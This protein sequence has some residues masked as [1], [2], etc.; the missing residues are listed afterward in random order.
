[1]L[2]YIGVLV[3]AIAMGIMN[4]FCFIYY[5]KLSRYL[6][7]KGEYKEYYKHINT[8]FSL[9]LIIV[10]IFTMFIFPIMI[11]SSITSS[12]W[13]LNIRD[14]IVD[15]YLYVGVPTFFIT[16]YVLIKRGI[17]WHHQ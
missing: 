13:S 3:F 11:I 5:D 4:G 12:E 6:R 7:A 10:V 9:S 1:M 17:L 2:I 14:T 15:I 8:I 16:L